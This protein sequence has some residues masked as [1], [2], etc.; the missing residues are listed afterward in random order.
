MSEESMLD[1]ELHAFIDGELDADRRRAVAARLVADPALSQRVAQF[2]GDQA[3][4]ARLFG[5]LAAAP[6][7]E[8]LV[9]RVDSIGRGRR[10]TSWRWAAGWGA[11]LAASLVAAWLVLA[12]H[13]ASP[14]PVIAAALAARSGST[15]A[16]RHLDAGLDEKQASDR[17]LQDALAAPVR[18]P[19]LGKAGYRLA[20]L[21]L[22]RD[23][24]HGTSVQISYRDGA[25]HLF[26]VYLH[27][28]SG[29]DRF[30]LEERGSQRIC[31][32]ENE[33]MAAVMVGEMSSRDMLR[34][35][36]LTY[37]DLNF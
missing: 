1:L 22:Y 30:A 21:D 10:P 28:S 13:G 36:S 11:A 14:D 12:P 6:L 34:V 2:R 15:V 35:A 32:W 23:K 9:Q 33:E 7:P 19:D 18:L 26:T 16:D 29:P 4:L 20:G 5:P 24:G 31:I 17:L 37:A 25:E 8:Q 3:R 27:P